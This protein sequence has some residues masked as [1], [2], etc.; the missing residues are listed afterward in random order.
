MQKR[1]FVECAGS[2][3]ERQTIEYYVL[4][5]RSVLRIEANRSLRVSGWSKGSGGGFWWECDETV[6]NSP[7]APSTALQRSRIL[8]HTV[9]SLLLCSSVSVR[10]RRLGNG[11]AVDDGCMIEG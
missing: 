5:S 9:P 7:R 1:M 2:R 6:A 10:C 11:D 4:D 8:I 3:L